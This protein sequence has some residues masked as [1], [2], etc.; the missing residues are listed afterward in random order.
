MARENIAVLHCMCVCVCASCLWTAYRLSR[1]FIVKVP[2]HTHTQRQDRCE[3][4]SLDDSARDDNAKKKKT[5]IIMI[6]FIQTHARQCG[7][8]TVFVTRQ[9]YNKYYI[10]VHGTSRFTR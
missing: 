3:H 4:F 5:R 9:K 6:I 1:A 10:R 8:Y 2:I 7:V